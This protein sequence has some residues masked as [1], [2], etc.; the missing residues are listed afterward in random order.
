MELK[1]NIMDY[2]KF[3]GADIVQEFVQGLKIITYEVSEI[4]ITQYNPERRGYLGLM[5]FTGKKKVS[6]Q[7]ENRMEILSDGKT[8][9]GYEQ[10]RR[11]Q[12]DEAVKE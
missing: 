12:I 7:L 9:N 6:I 8:L 11:M 2:R 10:I 1:S 3:Q 4:E 5:D